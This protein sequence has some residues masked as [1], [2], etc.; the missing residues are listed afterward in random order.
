M[1]TFPRQPCELAAAPGVRSLGQE[2]VHQHGTRTSR[3]RGTQSFPRT[4]Q[5]PD[6]PR[7]FIT[8]SPS[9]CGSS[10]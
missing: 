5:R 6:A 4:R 7:E 2:R 9:P 10:T 1:N 8:S 3:F